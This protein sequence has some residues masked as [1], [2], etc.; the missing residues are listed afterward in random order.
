MA[1]RNSSTKPAL[2]DEQKKQVKRDNFARVL[3]KRMDKAVKAIRLVGD[4]TNP[5]Y[6]Y[7]GVQTTAVIKGLQAAVNDVM[8]RFEGVR[9]K[10]GGF[11]LPS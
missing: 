4:C 2:T 3:P 10:S 11:Q 1:K 9:G 7:D 5:T 8:A 6:L